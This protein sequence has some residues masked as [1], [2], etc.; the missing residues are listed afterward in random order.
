M[1]V[2]STSAARKPTMTPGMRAR[3]PA[4]GPE[5]PEDDVDEVAAAADRPSWARNA[6][7]RPDS[8]PRRP[9]RSAAKLAGLREQRRHDHG[10][11]HADE[12]EQREV[13]DQDRADP[14]HAAPLE[15]R[16]RP[17][18]RRGDDQ[19]EQ[20]QNDDLADEVDPPRGQGDEQDDDGRAERDRR[21]RA[22][23]PLVIRRARRLRHPDS[24][25]RCPRSR[26]QDA[27]R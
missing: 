2:I 17:V 8:S 11:H 20:A 10:E 3:T 18:D 25:P 9:G 1:N 6:L 12:R 15:R 26:S 22:G 4:H 21:R 5:L 19:R 14:R 13:D 23:L 27:P 7:T 24:P 16:H